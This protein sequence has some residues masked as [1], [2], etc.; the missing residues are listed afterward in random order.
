MTTHLQLAS[1]GTPAAR[2]AL[3]TILGEYVAPRGATLYR[4]AYVT[5]LQTMGYGEN[6]ARQAVSRSVTA[7]WLESERNGRRSLM[8]VSGRTRCMLEAGY[9]RIY[10]FGEPWRWSGKW[11]VVIVRVP[12]SERHVRDRMRTQLAWSGFGSLGGGVWVTPHLGRDG[13]LSASLNGEHAAAE[14]LSLIAETGGIGNAAEIVRRAWDLDEIG[15]HYRSFLADFTD[16]EPTAP[17]ETFAAL[18]A[19]VHAW[20]KF[21]FVDPDL[22]QELLPADWPRATARQVFTDR[23][24]RWIRTAEAYFDSLS[25]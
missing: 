1:V 8:T 9:P 15:R 13:E 23:H 22:P 25:T 11:L 17:E 16:V 3:L 20:R 12:E 2:S 5:A 21:P 10:N 7:G 4:D 19:M 24:A 6:T 18:T 14:M